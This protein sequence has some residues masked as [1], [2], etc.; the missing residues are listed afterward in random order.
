MEGV[1]IPEELKKRRM[2]VKCQFFVKYKT[3]ESQILKNF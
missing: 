2:D 1:E 3:L